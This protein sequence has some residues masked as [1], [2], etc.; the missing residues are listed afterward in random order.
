MLIQF[1]VS[2]FRSIAEEIHFSM[3]AARTSKSAKKMRVDE[4]NQFEIPSAKLLKSAVLYGAN[5]SGKSN[6]VQAIRFMRK[7]VLE[8]LTMQA[9]ENFEVSPFRFIDGFQGKPSTFEIVFFAPDKRTY[10]YGFAITKEVVAEEW[11]YVKDTNRESCLFER[12]GKKIDLRKKFAEGNNLESKTR[13]NGLFLAT[14]AQFNGK[15]SKLIIDW[16]RRIQILDG[17]FDEAHSLYSASLLTNEKIREKVSA[18]IQELDLSIQE[19]VIDKIPNPLLKNNQLLKLFSSEA[20]EFV[21]DQDFFQPLTR[22]NKF[23]SDGKLI[24]SEFVPLSEYESEG[25]KKLFNFAPMFLESLENQRIIIVDEL[26]A[27]LHPLLT[28]ALIK[29]FHANIGSGHCS[30]LIFTTHDTNLL[31][32]ELFRRDQIWFSEKDKFGATQLYS[33]YDYKL[34]NKKIRTDEMYEKNYLIGK[35]GAIPYLGNLRF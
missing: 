27:K 15:I 1:T 19:V 13:E 10:R 30:Q 16:F 4:E 33:L 2:N 14:V 35:Y 26:D 9:G 18:L 21:R 23:S 32:S 12:E 8:S 17:V 29:K 34:Q 7:A 11:L 3:E 20:L 22:H 5:A 25:T 31:T 24:G 28:I 6:F